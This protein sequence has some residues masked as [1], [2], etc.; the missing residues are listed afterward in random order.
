MRLN[1][2][3][4]LV[5]KDVNTVSI[6][7]FCM[8]SKHQDFRYL[9]R[10]FREDD[11][12]SYIGLK[13]DPELMLI[14]ADLV[15][16]HKILTEDNRSLKRAKADFEI[17]EMK[18]RY[19]IATQILDI[20]KDTL[21]IEVLEVF[22]DLGYIFDKAF[23]IGPQLDRI[24]RALTGLK[25]QIR[26]KEVNFKKRYLADEEENEDDDIMRDLDSKALSLEAELELGYKINVKKTSMMR[27]TNLINRSE[28]KREAH[29]KGKH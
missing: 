25:N 22:N 5:K 1:N 26:I 6:Y 27:W 21:E 23:P 2:K 18:L 16:E 3:N 13:H 9:I 17:S 7:D 10:N 20:Y 14:Y 24:F 29:G 15:K 11:E 28:L 4:I 19:S 12:D 8:I